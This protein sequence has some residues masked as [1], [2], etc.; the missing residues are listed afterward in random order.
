MGKS[1]VSRH[2]TQEFVRRWPIANPRG[3]V[4]R[5]DLTATQIPAIDAAWVA[6]NYQPK[7]SRTAQQ[8]ELLALST[9]L[10]GE[11]LRADEY[12]IGVPMHNWGPS[13]VFKLWADQ[14]VRFG[15]TMLL[16]PAG[17]KGALGRRKVTFFVSAGRSYHPGAEDSSRNLL[18]PWLRTFFGNLGVTELRF[19]FVDGAGALRSGRVDR[20]AFMA[21]H[22]AAVESFFTQTSSS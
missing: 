10:T 7:E 18:V 12:V 8:T 13:S 21:P 20:D 9:E 16:T 15:E 19:H 2:L 17:M 6:A 3:E 1:S 14:I 22:L 5:R 4:I 11:L